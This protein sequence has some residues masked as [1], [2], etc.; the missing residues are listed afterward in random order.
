MTDW[1]QLDHP[2]PNYAQFQRRREPISGVITLHATAGALDEI[3]PDTGAENVSG[4]ISTRVD[5]GSYY[6]LCDTDSRVPQI[7]FVEYECY[8]TGIHR[9]NRHCG[10]VAGAFHPNDLSIGDPNTKKMLDNMA[11]DAVDEWREWKEPSPAWV[12]ML[13]VEQVNS[14][15]MQGCQTSSQ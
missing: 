2:N 4:F 9:A 6:R 5:P 14:R 10:S 7:P 3:A 1:Y 12:R 15:S 13:S 11:A 8:H